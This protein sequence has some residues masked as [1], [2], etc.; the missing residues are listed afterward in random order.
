MNYDTA[1]DDPVSNK[2]KE[3]LGTKKLAS[4][5]F[6]EAPGSFPIVVPQEPNQDPNAYDFACKLCLAVE[7]IISVADLL[8]QRLRTLEKLK[9]MGRL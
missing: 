5:E 6:S 8:N 2:L 3:I 1:V 9:A 7:K 4:T